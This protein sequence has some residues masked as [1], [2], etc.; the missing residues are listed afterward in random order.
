MM[1]KSYFTCGIRGHHAYKTN[2]TP[3]LNKMLDCKKDN[4]EEALCYN[5][6]SIGICRKNGTLVGH[7]P[8]EL[9]RL[10]DYFMKNK[11]EN[12]VSAVVAGHR[13]CKTE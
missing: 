8:V 12:F 2:W 9:S 10:I 3:V 13:K 6:H 5:K 4:Q 1:Y 7:I 11:E